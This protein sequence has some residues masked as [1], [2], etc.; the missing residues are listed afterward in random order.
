M[1]LMQF[2]HQSKTFKDLTNLRHQEAW[3]VGWGGGVTLMVEI[4]NRAGI[5]FISVSK[6][7]RFYDFSLR[8]KIHR[9]KLPDISDSLKIT[10]TF[11]NGGGAGE[12]LISLE[13]IPQRA[14]S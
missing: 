1:S 2:A 3:V 10:T 12:K 14:Q 13:V 4:F 11:R 8:L 9:S 6:L 5:L 7:H